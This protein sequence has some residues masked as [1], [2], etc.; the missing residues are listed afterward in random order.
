MKEFVD[1]YADGIQGVLSCF[2][3][4]LFRGYLPIM[5][6]WA[7]AEFLNSLDL[8][9]NNLKPLLVENAQRVKDHALKMATHHNRPYEYLRAKIRMEDTAQQIVKRDGITE[10]LVCIFSIVQPWAGVRLPLREGPAVC[11]VGK[12]QVPATVFL[13]H[14]GRFRIDSRAAS[15]VVSDGDSGL[16]ERSRV[17]GPKTD[18]QSDPLYEA[19]QCVHLD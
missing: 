17:A 2:D 12:T 16:S 6:G 4:M 7:M 11:A 5:S 10:G 14:R 19:R 13:F 18:G 3:R 15:D 8:S 9:F 1:K